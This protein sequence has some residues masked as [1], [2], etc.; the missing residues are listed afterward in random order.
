MVTL[1][2]LGGD[3]LDNAEMRKKWL[4]MHKNPHLRSELRPEIQYS[5]ERSAAMG[6]DPYLR[7]NAFICSAAELAEA[8]ARSQ[9]LLCISEPVM[10]DL[11]EFVAGTGFVVALS[12][13]DLRLLKV[14]GDDES[15]AWARSAHF[16][17]GSMWTEES[18]GTNAGALCQTLA[19]PISVYG[20]EHYC[21][22]SHVAA[23]SSAPIIDNGR[24]LG[25]LSMAAPFNKVTNHTLGMVVAAVKHI[26][27][28]LALA[29]VNE[30]HRTVMES[31]SE[32]VLA[33]DANGNI[34]FM[35]DN[36]AQILHITDQ[37]VIGRNLARL[38]GQHAENHY[39]INKVTQSRTIVDESFH[40][41]TRDN[42]PVSCSVNCNPLNNQDLKEGGTVV[43]LKEGQRVNR[44]IR[45]WVGDGAKMTFQDVI[46][47]DARFSQT[48]N[49]ARAAASSASNVLLL[50]ESGTGK[51][52]VAQA[53]HNAS[54][55]RSNPYIAINC[56]A[57]PR[58]LIAS[59]LF[60]YEEGAFTG[61]KK[62]GSIGKFEL[63]DQ[64]TI[65]LDEIG[66]M[67]LDLQASLLRVLEEKK[68]LRLGG[69]R[70]IPVDVRI[71][72]ATNK[73]LQN[74]IA[75]QRFR[76]DLY[77]RLAVISITIPPLR[78]RSDDI[79]VLAEEFIQ[80]ICRRFNKPQ[81][82]MAPEVID[83]F[84][85]YRWPGN[86]REIQNVIEGAIQLAPGNVITYD[87]IAEHLI[88][89]ELDGL[90]PVPE[91]RRGSQT[92]AE[93]ERQM[94]IDILTQH[95]YNKSNVAKAMGISRKTLYRRLSEHG[96]V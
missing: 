48:L 60:G 59:E 47:K 30:F 91:A 83:A 61:A 89:E 35:N 71:I 69:T 28:T 32:G 46:G 58:D 67:P 29:R 16:V 31:M 39:F 81:M 1:C 53:M 88:K 22:F 55:R 24:I 41:I 2:P 40:L 51:D 49:N 26:T 75:R 95:Q 7:E 18:V 64:G 3:L 66:D 82:T 11:Y 86:I 85:R 33:L 50:G 79:L 45:K 25:C 68:V 15:L 21:L 62:G 73:D 70:L 27:S 12:D 65:F 77:Y 5:W 93:M 44:L 6:V 42:V 13:S 9:H 20:Y 17:E 10:R 76:R 90:P 19:K 14:I 80:R 52:V 57:F 72:A 23:S 63:A 94:L 84:L 4:Q 56:A 34:T 37:A 96:L 36:C 43:I 87:L 38:L 74:E 54:P 8:Q 92:V 78:E